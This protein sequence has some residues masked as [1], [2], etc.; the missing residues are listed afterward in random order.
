MFFYLFNSL[1]SFTQTPS[2]QVSSQQN[3]PAALT[4]HWHMCYIAAIVQDSD[5][6]RAK[7]QTFHCNENGV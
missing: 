1:N 3:L 5:R 4:A 7:V 2:T 6:H